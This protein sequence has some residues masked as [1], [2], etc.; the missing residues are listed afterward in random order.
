MTGTVLVS[1]IAVLIEV[2]PTADLG[3]PTDPEAVPLQWA[4]GR[5]LTS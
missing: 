5:V 1:V 3:A 2:V 4:N